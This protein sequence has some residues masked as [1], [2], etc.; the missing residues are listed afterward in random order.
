[1]SQHNGAVLPQTHQN[2]SEPHGPVSDLFHGVLGSGR[3]S[4]SQINLI[5]NLNRMGLFMTETSDFNLSETF[6]V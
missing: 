1:M 3:S 2:P 4:A 5:L 6:T